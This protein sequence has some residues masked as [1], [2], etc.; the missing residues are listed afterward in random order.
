MNISTL[1]EIT[2]ND[3]LMTSLGLAIAEARMVRSLVS[4]R[5]TPIAR[6]R[7]D[8]RDWIEQLDREIDYLEAKLQEIRRSP[9]DAEAHP[10]DAR[11]R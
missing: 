5:E 2:S 8:G 7:A 11:V 1:C 10:P 9:G 4:K 3:K 6:S